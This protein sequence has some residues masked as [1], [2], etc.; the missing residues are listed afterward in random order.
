MRY[1]VILVPFPF[2]DLTRSKVRPAV[3]LTEALGVHRHVVVTPLRSV[4]RGPTPVFTHRGLSPH[5]FAS[6]SGAH[7]PLKRA[8]TSLFRQRAFGRLRRLVPAVHRRG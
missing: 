4:M 6:M 3:C 5:Q 2:D 7:K 1:R 8:G